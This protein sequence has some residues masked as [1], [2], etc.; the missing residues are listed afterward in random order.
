MKK[1]A[2]LV[3]L[4]AMAVVLI[5]NNSAFAFQETEIS[6]KISLPPFDIIQTDPSSS[7]HSKAWSGVWEAYWIESNVPFLVIIEKVETASSRE[8]KVTGI[9]AR[10]EGLDS[11]YTRFKKKKVKNDKIEFTFSSAGGKFVTISLEMSEDLK[12]L[13]AE[14]KTG[15][16]IW[17]ATMARIED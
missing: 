3:I 8:M 15:W 9:Y 13:K 10:G 1:I 11:D 7:P 6:R 14:A 12:T 2:F 5:L 16:G 17:H 4:T